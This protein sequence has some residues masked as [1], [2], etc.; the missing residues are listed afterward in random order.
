R[1]VLPARLD[2]LPEL[3]QHPLV[4]ELGDRKHLLLSLVGIAPD[5]LD[6]GHVAEADHVGDSVGGL[7][8][9]RL[10]RTEIANARQELDLRLDRPAGHL[11]HQLEHL[12]RLIVYL[13]YAVAVEARHVFDEVVDYRSLQEHGIYVAVIDEDPEGVYLMAEHVAARAPAVADQSGRELHIGRKVHRLEA[14]HVVH[15]H[16][17]RPFAV[18]IRAF[19]RFEIARIATA[20]I[21]TARIA[22][23]LLRHES[24]SRYCRYLPARRSASSSFSRSLATTSAGAEPVKPAFASLARARAAYCSS[25]SASLRSFSRSLPESTDSFMKA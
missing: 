13:E 20:R 19:A 2:E 6:I 4:G 24:S 25:F 12:G 22:T 16:A 23:A 11:Q 9:S 17:D 10:A 15:V 7:E 14:E 1:E 8:H 3:V 18:A 21:A 5:E